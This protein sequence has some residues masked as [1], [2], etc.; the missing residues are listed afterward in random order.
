MVFKG[1]RVWGLG[2]LVLWWFRILWFWGLEVLG[3]VDVGREE[4]CAEDE[5]RATSTEH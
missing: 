5:P 3:W 2:F 4:V 1:F